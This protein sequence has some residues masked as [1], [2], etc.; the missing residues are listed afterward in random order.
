MTVTNGYT[1]VAT[2]KQRLYN[3]DPDAQANST[4]DTQFENIIEAASR[5]IDG[6]RGRHFY[7][8]SETR[9]YTAEVG[10]RVVIDDLITLTTLLTD[11]D[12]DGTFERTWTAADYNLYP[13][14]AAIKLR[15]YIAIER[16]VPG[17]LTFPTLR[18]G[19]SV[20]GV[21][22]FWSAV[23]EA[24]TE[25]CILISMRVWGRKDLLFGVSGNADLGTQQVISTIARDGEILLLL[26]TI[27]KR[28]T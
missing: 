13:Y 27:P 18:K 24:I 23:P 22:G 11:E 5:W 12:G 16:S 1:D 20:T 21:F 19:V 10:H 6:N 26:N 15:P 8:A 3:G 28:V 14:N 9:Y 7:T 2:L 4:N 25:A 17:S